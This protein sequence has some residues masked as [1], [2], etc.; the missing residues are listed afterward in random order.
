[1]AK[2]QSEDDDILFQGDWLTIRAMRR[3]NGSLPARE[4]FDGLDEQGQA[5]VLAAGKVLETTLRSG[6][7]PAGRAGKVTN[8]KTGVWEL[9]VTKPGSTPPHL[10]L[11][12]LRKGR[13]LWAACGFTKQQNKLT[14]QEISTGDRIAEE[15]LGQQ[16]QERM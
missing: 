14:A 15:W 6:R 10:R 8:S 9:K 16:S 11:F 2:L 3:L 13:T 4:W 7:P 12:Y 5:K 1:M